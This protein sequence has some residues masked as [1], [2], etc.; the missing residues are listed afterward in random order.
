MEPDKKDAPRLR[1]VFVADGMPQFEYALA[2][3]RAV[4]NSNRST[5]RRSLSVVGNPWGAFVDLQLRIGNE[6]RCL[7]GCDDRYDLIVVA[8]YDERR[9]VEFLQILS[10]VGL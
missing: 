2:F 7:A 8:L 10:L 4:K 3:T 6:L 9:N 5:L 1:G